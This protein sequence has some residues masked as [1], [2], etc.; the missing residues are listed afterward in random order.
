MCRRTAVPIYSGSAL[1]RWVD[2]SFNG[3]LGAV[4]RLVMRSRFAVS[5]QTLMVRSRQSRKREEAKE[6]PH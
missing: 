3:C 2:N 6:W 1:F 5:Y 4:R